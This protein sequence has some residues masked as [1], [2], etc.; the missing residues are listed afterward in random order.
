[1][2]PF[3]LLSGAAVLSA[4][5]A[6]LPSAARAGAYEDFFVGVELD[7]PAI[8][9]PLLAKGFD[10]N[11]RDPR[12]QHALY[13]A[14]REG[15]MQVAELLLRTPGLQ[16]DAVNAAGET[17]LMMAALRGQVKAMQRLLALGAQVHREGWTPLHYAASGES[18]AAITLLLDEGAEIDARAPSG[19]TPLMMAA[20]FGGIDGA[21]LL[22]RRGADPSLKNKAGL[23]AAEYAR[24]GD[25]G[26]LA[27][28]LEKRAAARLS[29]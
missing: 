23:D 21:R 19:N 7:R 5:L 1:L 3:R 15:S 28:E 13:V 8:V 4:A 12:G 20:G 11:A 10:V 29:R 25:R 6:L 2:K 24:R 18:G 14:L 22:L 16:P 9:A 27:E 17:L 26:A